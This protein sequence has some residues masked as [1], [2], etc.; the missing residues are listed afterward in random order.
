M[1]STKLLR[2]FMKTSTSLLSIV[3]WYGTALTALPYTV[4]LVPGFT[5][6]ANHFNH[7][8]NNRLANFFQ[9]PPPDGCAVYVFDKAIQNYGDPYTYFD[10]F[11]WF[12]ASDPSL[13]GPIINP[14]EGFF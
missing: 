1:L 5:M 11:G 4:T 13:D 3:L 14:G 8:P 9:P 12:S 6:V 2:V 10:G 7:V